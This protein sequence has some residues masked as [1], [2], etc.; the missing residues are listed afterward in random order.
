MFTGDFIMTG[1]G[2]GPDRATL[3][4][5]SAQAFGMKEAIRVMILIRSVCGGNSDVGY[6]R[7]A[8][9]RLALGGNETFAQAKSAE[10]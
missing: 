2:N 7:A 10:P 3:D 6:H 8:T 9:H 1:I 4:T 5:S